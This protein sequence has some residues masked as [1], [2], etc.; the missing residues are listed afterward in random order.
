MAA[1]QSVVS[2]NTA[3][4]S[5]W[6]NLAVVPGLGT[7]FLGRAFVGTTQLVLALTGFW[8]GLSD[9]E[10]NQGLGLGLVIAAVVWAAATAVTALRSSKVNT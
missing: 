9:A 5:L 4:L 3:W 6:A 2:R 8:L 10:F 7:F 1:A